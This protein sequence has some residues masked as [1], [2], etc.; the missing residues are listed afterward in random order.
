MDEMFYGCSSLISLPDLSKWNTQN[1]EE[2]N[3]MFRGCLNTIIIP[4]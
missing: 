3:D 4:F 1:V 2:K